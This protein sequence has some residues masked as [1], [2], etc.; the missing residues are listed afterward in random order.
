MPRPHLSR[1]PSPRWQPNQE[2]DAPTVYQNLQDTRR[3]PCWSFSWRIKGP[4]QWPPSLPPLPA[5][6]PKSRGATGPFY[7]LLLL[8]NS[9]PWP[10][11][12]FFLKL[13]SA[14]SGGK[15]KLQGQCRRQAARNVRPR[16]QPGEGGAASWQARVRAPDPSGS[17]GSG[18]AQH[19]RE[20]AQ[21]PRVPGW[22]GEG[23]KGQNL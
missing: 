13:Q 12:H 8:S 5:L 20:G 1:D 15:E 17:Q 22:A 3:C 7:F 4:L 9:C 2:E 19:S 10:F 14:L 11:E 21:D 6:T 18:R 23:A 16:E